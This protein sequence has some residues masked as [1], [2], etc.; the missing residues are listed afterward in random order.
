MNTQFLASLL[1]KLL[2]VGLTALA[3]KLHMEPDT[4]S[5]AALATD[6]ADILVI[7]W[8]SYAHWGMKKV[9]ETA[10]VIDQ[11]KGPKV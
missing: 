1:R 5:I 8:G 3:A 9:P 7:A 4:N 10:E 2:V 11:A 6:A